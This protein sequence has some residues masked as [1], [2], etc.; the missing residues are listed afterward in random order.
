MTPGQQF[1]STNCAQLLA[2]VAAQIDANAVKDARIKELEEKLA[3]LE[4][5]NKK[6]KVEPDA[7][8]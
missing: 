3:K 8:Q 1:L 4:K 2:E 7:P 5:P 6:P